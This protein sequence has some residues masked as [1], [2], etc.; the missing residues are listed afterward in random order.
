M[1]HIIGHGIFASE[2]TTM[3][4]KP[5]APKERVQKVSL[6]FYK[7]AAGNEPVREWLQSLPEDECNAIGQDLMDAQFAWPAEMPLCR[8]LAKGLFEIRTTLPD[9]IARVF[10]CFVDGNLVAL[11]GIIKKTQKTPPDDLALARKRMKE[12]TGS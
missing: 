10:V 6:K 2:G 5:V 11:H 3:V 8:P 9:K 7:T 1:V 12:T 4:R